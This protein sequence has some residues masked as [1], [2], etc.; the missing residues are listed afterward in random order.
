MKKPIITP[1][2]P[3]TNPLEHRGHQPRR[4]DEGHQA[5]NKVQGG[6]QGPTHQSAPANPPSGGSSGKPASG[7]GQKADK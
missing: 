3:P 6:H 4:L 5:P 7:S 1:T 2:N